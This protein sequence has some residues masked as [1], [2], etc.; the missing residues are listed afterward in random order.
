MEAAIIFALQLACL[1][2]LFAAI[3]LLRSLGKQLSFIRFAL[4]RQETK[5]LAEPK[6]S[7][8]EVERKLKNIAGKLK[9]IEESIS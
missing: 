1:A 3:A 5:S 4:A 2:L 9:E 7:F 8:E 6:P